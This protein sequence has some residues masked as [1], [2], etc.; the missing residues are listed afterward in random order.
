MIRG[1]RAANHD[2]S[3]SRLARLLKC[4]DLVE[5]QPLDAS[6]VAEVLTKGN[7]I[8]FELDISQRLPPDFESSTRPRQRIACLAQASSQ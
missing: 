3:C 1:V 6:G 7:M 8:T 5:S 2:A 4:S